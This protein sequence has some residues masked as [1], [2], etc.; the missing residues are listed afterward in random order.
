MDLVAPPKAEGPM[1][2]T[3]APSENLLPGLPP[4]AKAWLCHRRTSLL[5]RPQSWLLFGQP[6]APPA[7]SDGLHEKKIEL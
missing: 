3:E 6:N 7:A 1:A 5:P 2:L 4:L